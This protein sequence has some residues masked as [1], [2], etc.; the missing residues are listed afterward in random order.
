MVINT[1]ETEKRNKNMTKRSKRSSR[2]NLTLLGCS[3]LKNL[4]RKY[5]KGVENSRKVIKL[6]SRLLSTFGA[7]SVTR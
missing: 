1:K 5:E 7:L 4:S 6:G 2:T 3:F